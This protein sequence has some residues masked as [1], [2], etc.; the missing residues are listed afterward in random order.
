MSSK[1][2]FIGDSYKPNPRVPKPLAD[3]VE[4]LARQAHAIGTSHAANEDAWTQDRAARGELLDAIVDAIG[5]ALRA[6]SS[7]ITCEF[8]QSS[9]GITQKYLG[10]PGIY[11]GTTGPMKDIPH[12]EIEPRGNG[13]GRYKGSDLFLMVDKTWLELSYAG[14]WTTIEGEIGRCIATTRTL[15]SV[16]VINE[17]NISNVVDSLAEALTRE[18]RGKRA[19]RTAQLLE[20]A[21]RM[22]ALTKLI[23]T[24]L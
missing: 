5:P 19:T 20:R 13:R 22:R 15:G 23:R 21:D 24:S 7:R 9:A 4:A 11:A 8:T 12:P 1:V 3:Q 2:D 6:C 18:A 14:P 10:V 16:D 17:Y